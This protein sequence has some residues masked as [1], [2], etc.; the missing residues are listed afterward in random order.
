[1]GK[2]ANFWKSLNWEEN[3]KK[4][5]YYCISLATRTPI[6][7]FVEMLKFF[8]KMIFPLKRK[9]KKICE[10]GKKN[11]DYLEPQREYSGRSAWN[12]QN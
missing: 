9:K 11:R 8:Q 2:F 3:K 12:L 6:I 5:N 4:K 7:L 10:G 1:L